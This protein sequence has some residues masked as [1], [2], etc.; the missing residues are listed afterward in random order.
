MEVGIQPLQAMQNIAVIN[1]RP[2]IWGD[3]MLAL[4]RASGK[5][6]YIREDPTDTGC[7]CVIKRKG[8]DEV[9]RTFTVEDAKKAGLWNK[10]GPWQTAPKRM[11]QMR[12]RAFALR[13]VFTDVLKGMSIAEESEDMKDMGQAERVDQPRPE[14]SPPAQTRTASVK[15]KLRKK[16]DESHTAFLD[17][18]AWLARVIADLKT[19]RTPDAMA[20]L[21]AEINDLDP[22]AERDAAKSAYKARVLA[23]KEEMNK[24]AEETQPAETRP[25]THQT[26]ANVFS[27]LIEVSDH[28]VSLLRQLEIA[29]DDDEVDAVLDMARGLIEGEAVD[30]IAKAADERKEA[31]R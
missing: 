23:L 3:A 14:F 10:Q 27:D 25:I 22:C 13:D 6:E 16:P 5:L 9:T 11:M 26:Q 31:F 17:K 8:E 30:R 24:P 19:A 29:V 1:G 21:K 20:S 4:V 2:S 15:E 18:K 12:A 7:T 28:E